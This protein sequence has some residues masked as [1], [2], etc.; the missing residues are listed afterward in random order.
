[1]ETI[2]QASHSAKER[3]ITAAASRG[4]AMHDESVAK[5]VCSRE[6]EFAP[7]VRYGLTTGVM[8]RKGDLLQRRPIASG[9]EKSSK[10]NPRHIGGFKFI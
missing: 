9:E 6:G 4:L 2:T 7:R 5:F 1:M 8:F 10:K 3:R